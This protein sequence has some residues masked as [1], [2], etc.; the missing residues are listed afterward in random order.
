M[1]QSFISTSAQV[2]LLN[3]TA[4]RLNIVSDAFTSKKQRDRHRMVYALLQD[5]LNRP[6]GIHALQLRTQTTE[7]ENNKGGRK[8]DIVAHIKDQE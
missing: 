3:T 8:D 7:E 1:S 6:G 5:E 2:P 4:N